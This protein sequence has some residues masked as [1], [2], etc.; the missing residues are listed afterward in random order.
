MKTKLP[1]EQRALR[2]VAVLAV[3]G[4]IA[5]FALSAYVRANPAPM[6]TERRIYLIGRGL[7]KYFFCS[8]VVVFFGYFFAHQVATQFGKTP[9]L[10]GPSG[11]LPRSGWWK[12]ALVSIAGFIG[13]FVLLESVGWLEPV[14]DFVEE[15][16]PFPRWGPPGDAEFE[17]GR[18]VG[19]TFGLGI[20]SIWFYYFIPALLERKR[21][22]QVQ[23]DAA[24]LD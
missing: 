8:T 10:V 24:A 12:R 3:L 13:L 23:S 5:F 20:L 16:I 18:R 14:A 7:T 17:A 21:P 19:H 11:K 2:V 4:V 1:W 22:R 15:V 6:P 9:L